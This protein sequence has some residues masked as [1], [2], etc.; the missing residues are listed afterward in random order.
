MPRPVLDAR[1][2]DKEL[3]HLDDHREHVGPHP[4]HHVAVRAER[5]VGG[6]RDACGPRQ[7]AQWGPRRGWGE[8]DC[9]RRQGHEEGQG[10]GMHEKGGGRG[11]LKAGGGR[12]VGWDP[13]LPGSPYGPRRTRAKNS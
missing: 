6:A 2:P 1:V 8:G 10:R 3:A 9:G 4:V 7:K 5:R 12:E 13:L 11:G